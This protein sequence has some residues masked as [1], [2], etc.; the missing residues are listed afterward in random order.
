MTTTKI[1][2]DLMLAGST[3]WDIGRFTIERFETA[4]SRQSFD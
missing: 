1:L 2:A 3:G 4:S